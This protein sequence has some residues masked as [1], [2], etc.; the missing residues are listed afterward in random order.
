MRT[1]V[2][3]HLHQ[4]LTLAKYQTDSREWMFIERFRKQIKVIS[5]NECL[6]ILK[7][8]GLKRLLPWS[9]VSR[10]GW[11]DTVSLTDFQNNNFSTANRNEV[12]NILL[13]QIPDKEELSVRLVNPHLTKYKPLQKRLAAYQMLGSQKHQNKQ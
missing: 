8:Y 10:I 13:V 5:L 2:D 4:A 11:F 9:C 12:D 1:W 3:A 6:K 7:I